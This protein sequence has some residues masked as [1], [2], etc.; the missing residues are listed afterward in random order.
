MS[1]DFSIKS[2]APAYQGDFLPNLCTVQ[3][4]FHLVV[5][6]Q[7]LAV[8]LSIADR[9]VYAFDWYEFGL[10]SIMVQWVVLTS[11]ACL[12]PLRPWFRRHSPELSGVVSYLVVMLITFLFT[13]LG[14]VFQE[15]GIG[16]D[17]DLL[18]SNMLLTAVFSGIVLRYFYLQQQ[19]R[20]QQQAELKA[21]IEALQ[22]RIRPHFLFNS[23]NSIASLIVIDPDVAER[24][25][26]DLSDLFRAS[27]S[28]PGL[29][30]LER[31]IDVCRRFC[32]IEQTRLGD[33]LRISWQIDED[34]EGVEVPSLLLQPIIENAIYHGIQPLPEGGEVLVR[35]QIIDGF[36]EVE[37]TNPLYDDKQTT[38]QGNG[39]ALQ[40]IINRLEAYFDKDAKLEVKAE[41]SKYSVF[42][43]YPVK[44]VALAS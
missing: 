36:C 29:I 8:A 33:R 28:E 4:V 25:V 3:A 41:K 7:L 39:I 27:L 37:I 30:P 35:I 12:C 40:N 21:R 11:A 22:S 13:F 16:I 26:E 9:G 18:L 6:G 15:G 1:G 14:A 44:K 38:H 43:R 24:L 2:K 42:V 31:E 34:L 5:V 32:R 10:L 17:G 20:N 19:V 23:M